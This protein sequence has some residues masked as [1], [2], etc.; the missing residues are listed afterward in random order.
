M[1]YS[2][3]VNIQEDDNTKD[4]LQQ[5]LFMSTKARVTISFKIKTM[6]FRYP[7]LQV[8]TYEKIISN[9]GNN[10]NDYTFFF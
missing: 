5:N 3:I 8:K 9:F 10:H 7:S 6:I 2:K 4:T 1:N